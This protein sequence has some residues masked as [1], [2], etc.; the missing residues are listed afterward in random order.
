MKT[1]FFEE[2]PGVLSSTRL[3]LIGT[4]VFAMAMTAYEA[5]AGHADPVS[6]GIMFAA[7]LAAPGGMKVLQS[8]SE[9]PAE[10]KQ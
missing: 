9:V 8:K 2:A 5:I 4:W 3:V 10:V 7:L 6:L 1:G